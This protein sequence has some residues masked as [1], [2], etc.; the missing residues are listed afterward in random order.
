MASVWHASPICGMAEVHAA[1][2]CGSNSTRVATGAMSLTRSHDRQGRKPASRSRAARALTGL[3]RSGVDSLQAIMA[4]TSFRS[5][6]QEREVCPVPRRALISDCLSRRSGA[7]HLAWCRGRLFK[8][9]VQ[10]RACD[11]NRP[12]AAR[13]FYLAIA[14][15]A[16]SSSP[17]LREP[18][19][20]CDQTQTQTS[21]SAGGS[22]QVHC[23]RYADALSDERASYVAGSTEGGT[24]VPR[25]LCPLF[26]DRALWTQHLTEYSATKIHSRTALA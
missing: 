21:I 13:G 3:R 7:A 12:A 4:R 25:P 19:P 10:T 6:G 9:N 17:T 26:A 1:L 16:V 18:S 8:N 24:E 11:Q 2:R 20:I 5:V 15:S 23:S 22:V 14:R